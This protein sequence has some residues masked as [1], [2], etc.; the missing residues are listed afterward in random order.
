MTN[1]LVPLPTASAIADDN[2]KGTNGGLTEQELR[3]QREVEEYD[4]MY[5]SLISGA[6]ENDMETD[7]SACTNFS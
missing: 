4:R 2:N 5:I 7:D 3:L 6:E 1:S